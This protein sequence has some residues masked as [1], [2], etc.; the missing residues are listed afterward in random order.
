MIEMMINMF[1]RITIMMIMISIT[2]Q[3][4]MIIITTLIMIVNRAK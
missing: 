4:V 1:T 2:M 3:P